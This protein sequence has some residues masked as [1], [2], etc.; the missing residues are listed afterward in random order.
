M[1]YFVLYFHTNFTELYFLCVCVCVCVY[2]CVCV[3]MHVCVCDII[4][5]VLQQ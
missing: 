1:P 2:V 5:W 4:L 3:C